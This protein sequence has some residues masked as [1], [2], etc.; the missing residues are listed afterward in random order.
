MSHRA[1]TLIEL[2]V[3]IAIIGLMSTIAV[4]SLGSARIQ[5]ADTK[6]KAELVQISKALEL[7][8]SNNGAY[9][10][11]GGSSNWEGACTDYGPY[12]D[13]YVDSTHDAWI[14]GLTPTYMLKLPHDPETGK[15]HTGRNAGCTAA[16]SCILYTSNGID[17]KV[18]NDCMGQGAMSATDPFSDPHRPTWGWTVYTSAARMW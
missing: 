15:D 1:F 18:L 7:Y 9:P 4:V 3:V 16:E 13:A 12:P 17:Y 2:L 11:T 14:P 5:A 10:S 8:Y 6:R